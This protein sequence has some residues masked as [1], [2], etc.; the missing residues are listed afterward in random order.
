MSARLQRLLTVTTTGCL[1]FAMVAGMVIL[2]AGVI[3][4]L[5]WAL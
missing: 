3:V 5:R 1:I 2:A 4:L